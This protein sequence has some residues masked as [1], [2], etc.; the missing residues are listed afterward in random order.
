MSL[1][2]MAALSAGAIR[3]PMCGVLITNTSDYQATTHEIHQIGGPP[4]VEKLGEEVTLTCGRC[5]W[6]KRTDNWRQFL[7]TK[8]V[9]TK[10]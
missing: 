5:G 9:G 8:P 10:K 4:L 2:L 6:Q 3:C 1:D 7:A